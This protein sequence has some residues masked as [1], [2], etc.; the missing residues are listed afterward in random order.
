MR[1][2]ILVDFFNPPEQV[3]LHSCKKKLGF[4]DVSW[5]CIAYLVDWH[6]L[7]GKVLHCL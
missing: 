5:A 7:L 6:V 2:C 1:F 4:S 3:S